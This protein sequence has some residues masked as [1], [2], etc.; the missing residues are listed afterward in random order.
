MLVQASV[1][2]RLAASLCLVLCFA[3]PESASS[4]TV[5]GVIRDI[6]KERASLPSQKA[7][8]RRAMQRPEPVNLQAVRP[9]QTVTINST[10]PGT[11]EA[12]FEKYLDQQIQQL[13][14][15]SEK[16]KSQSNRGEVWLR[17]A[18]AYTEKATLVEKRV[19]EKYDEDLKDYLAK[20]STSR[21]RLN[22]APAQSYNKKAVQLYQWYLRDNPRS[23]NI[24]QVLFFLGYNSMAL[25]QNAL[26]IK[27]YEKLS[28]EFPNSEFL[29]EAN[30]SLA[31]HYFDLGTRKTSNNRA[32]FAKAEKHYKEVLK[33]KSRLTP[34]ATYKL[35]WVYFKLGRAKDALVYISRLVKDGKSNDERMA[36]AQRLAREAQKEL[37]MFYSQVGDYNRSV[38]YFKAL[39]PANEVNRS[40]EALAMMYSD[41]GNRAGANFLLDYLAQNAAI[42]EEKI[43]EFAY[44]KYLL[45][46]SKSGVVNTRNEVFAMVQKFGPQ[47]PWGKK[48]AKQGFYKDAIS[49]ME[50]TLRA[51]TLEVHKLAQ[52][53]EDLYNMKKAEEAYKL[54][55][56]NFASFDKK[57]EM[58]FF[59]AELLYDMKDYY[60]ASE[61]YHSISQKK[62]EYSSKAELNALLS[63]EKLL[64][65]SE[66]IKAQ[67]GK[68]TEILKLNAAEERFK[69]Y[70]E[71]Y[72]KNPK[73]TENRVEVMYKLASMLYS[74]NYLDEA[75]KY[76]K[77]VS[78]EFPK[79]Q[80]AEYSTNLILDIY[81]LR[82]DYKGLERVGLEILQSN[83]TTNQT[84]A[85]D[86]KSMVEKSAFK[87]A[88]EIEKKGKPLDASKAY[89]DFYKKYPRSEL[90]GLALY[91]AALN[92]EK[93]EKKLLA[94]ETYTH[95]RKVVP[96]SDE[97]SIE[98]YLFTGIIKES[99]ADFVGAVADYES[100]LGLVAADKVNVDLYYNI[101]VI[102]EALRNFPKAQAFF[103]L[104]MTHSK[105]KSN[106]NITF[107][108]A[109]LAEQLKLSGDAI[110]NY[111][112]FV[113]TAG[114]SEDLKIEAIG[115]L[116]HLYRATR[117]FGKSKQAFDRS[118]AIQNSLKTKKNAKYAAEG[119]FIDTERLYKDLRAINISADPA[120]QQVELQKKIKL[121][122]DLQKASDKVIALDVPEWI[123]AGLTRMGQGY[124]HL[125]YSLVT[126]PVPKDLTPEELKEYRSKIAEIAEPFKQNAVMAYEKALERARSLAGYGDYYSTA[127]AELFNL[128]PNK[129][130]YGQE[131]AFVMEM[132]DTEMPKDQIHTRLVQN[133]IDESSLRKELAK[134]L[135][136]DP[137][138][139]T[140]HEF[141]A[142]YYYNN[143]AYQLAALHLDKV[144]SESKNNVRIMNNLGVIKAKL[145]NLSEAEEMY[146][147]ALAIQPDYE[148]ANIN[149]T[150]AYIEKDGFEAPAPN[151]EILYGKTKGKISKGDRMAMDI[152]V[153]H[154]VALA[155]QG[156]F[157]GS[158][159]VY[160]TVLKADGNHSAAARNLAIAVITG[161]KKKDQGAE[162]LQKYRSLASKKKDFDTIKVLEGILQT[163]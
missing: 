151:L 99:L 75:E 61:L 17:L 29:T 90:A 7:Q 40:L 24:D 34:V 101:G 42:S 111:E 94:L 72:L 5:G 49:Q 159:Q 129:T 135:E 109:E 60:K 36:S 147:K 37:P 68:S 89:L 104:Y 50:S 69:S 118:V 161:Q 114:V 106:L 140:A 130:Y 87:N 74:H 100:Y 20:K 157:D 58:R 62:T 10:E 137:K 149:F 124:Q 43:F 88:E 41:A 83:A 53:N 150:K 63:L 30:L 153:N 120:K 2:K 154:G 116:A 127:R 26:G 38:E 78:A 144:A 82:K 21:P 13:F 71:T 81:N 56:H 67:V 55:D 77:Q 139:I 113:N 158:V 70:A 152:A 163:L 146:K 3:L 27:Y 66:Q 54:Y 112:K 39:L 132:Y 65:S 126:A 143:K 9:V 51:Y 15:L 16:T 96:K 18:K 23:A 107:R 48:N 45:A 35:A 85:K 11:S 4:K 14:K 31:D 134:I 105:D 110:K 141:M 160:N 98:S 156:S 64:P 19:N 93:G 8:Q 6:K 1:N 128:A 162:V 103:N 32:E 136:S 28:K 97:R 33:T 92:F 148:A 133:E 47:S 145:G 73:N 80:Y 117:Q 44:K 76:F 119:L 108:I 123:V 142:N 125:A 25:N 115:R 95:F 79:T 22:L 122:E 59:Y 91:N 52:N 131:E 155:R 12:Q 121:V 86:V 84:I 102:Y 138:N 46:E 57:G